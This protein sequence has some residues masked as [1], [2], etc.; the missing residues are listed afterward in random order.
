M[1]THIFR[2]TFYLWLYRR[3]R[4]LVNSYNL[5]TPIIKLFYQVPG[6]TTRVCSNVLFG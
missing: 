2:F 5:L 1:N 4:L 3:Q 6:A